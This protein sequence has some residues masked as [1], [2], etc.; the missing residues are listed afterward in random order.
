MRDFSDSQLTIRLP[1]YLRPVRGEGR[2]RW[3]SS[4][5]YLFSGKRKGVVGSFKEYLCIEFDIPEEGI[6]AI[7]S[8]IETTPVISLPG[9][10][11]RVIRRGELPHF[12]DGVEIVVETEN[13]QVCLV[14]LDALFCKDGR[15]IHV[16]IMSFGSFAENEMTWREFLGSISLK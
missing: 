3:N 15:F 12:E 16:K 13:L 9:S 5:A 6:R 7:R 4:K 8:E 1:D 2:R 14:E 11:R 10:V